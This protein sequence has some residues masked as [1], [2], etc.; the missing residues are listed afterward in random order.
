MHGNVAEWVED[1][2][3][4]THAGAPSDGS[5]RGGDCARRVLKGGAWY[6]EAAMARSAAR[7]SYP[8]RSRLNIVGFRVV[9]PVE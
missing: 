3:N 9:R 1:C 5:A 2:W 4:P 7:L 6:H 8:K